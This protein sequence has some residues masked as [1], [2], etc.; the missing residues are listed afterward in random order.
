MAQTRRTTKYDNIIKKFVDRLWMAT[1]IVDGKLT[2]HDN[3][4]L[5]VEVS[6]YILRVYK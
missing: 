4:C 3:N 2:G 1:S 5:L 6:K